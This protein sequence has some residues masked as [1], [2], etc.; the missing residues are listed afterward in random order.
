[1][2]ANT[3]IMIHVLPGGGPEGGSETFMG[4]RAW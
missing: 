1:M 4:L 2:L 3:D